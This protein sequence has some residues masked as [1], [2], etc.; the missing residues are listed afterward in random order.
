[1][2]EQVGEDQCPCASGRKRARAPASD[3]EPGTPG[4]SWKVW[5][6]GSRDRSRR[7]ERCG[8]CDGAGGSWSGSSGGVGLRLTTKRAAQAL[9]VDRGSP[10]GAGHPAQQIAGRSDDQNRDDR[11]GDQQSCHQGGGGVAGGRG[12]Y[13]EEGEESPQQQE[14][15]HVGAVSPVVAHGVQ[16]IETPSGRGFCAVTVDI[17]GLPTIGWS[18]TSGS[19]RLPSAPQPLSRKGRVRA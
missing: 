4:S 5:S 16:R 8:P 9:F 18:K 13:G 6:R 19:F 15:Q 7:R 2:P 10:D 12:M 3:A 1:M 14:N 17:R 11:D